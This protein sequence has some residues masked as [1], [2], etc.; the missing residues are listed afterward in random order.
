MI[1]VAATNNTVYDPMY[2]CRIMLDFVLK[3]DKDRCDEIDGERRPS[4]HARKHNP[5]D[6]VPPGKECDINTAPNGDG[7][8]PD[9]LKREFAL[10]ENKNNTASRRSREGETPSWRVAR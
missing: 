8:N 5:E 2:W 10:H 1:R 4:M 6:L 3:Y 7:H 9:G